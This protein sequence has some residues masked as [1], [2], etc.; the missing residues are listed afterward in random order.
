MPRA[1]IGRSNLNLIPGQATPSNPSGNPNE[2]KA[3][4][5]IKI[6]PIFFLRYFVYIFIFYQLLIFQKEF[7]YLTLNINL[8]RVRQDLD[9]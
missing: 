7:S 9:N 2:I 5:E 3:K 4:N 8:Y 6:N 1:S